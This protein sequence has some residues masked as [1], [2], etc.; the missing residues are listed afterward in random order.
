MS[1]DVFVFSWIVFRVT[2]KVFSDEFDQ[3]GRTFV[4]GH[5]PRWNAIHK[6]DCTFSMEM[7]RVK[8]IPVRQIMICS[9][10]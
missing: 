3:D 7:A 2:A 9:K 4:D 8:T 6:N 1:R 5:D 10:Y